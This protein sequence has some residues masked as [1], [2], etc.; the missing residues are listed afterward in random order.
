MKFNQEEANQLIYRRRSVFPADYRDESVPDFIVNQMLENATRAPTHKNTEPWRFTVFTGN[1]IHRLA[2]FQSEVY[3]QV[4]VKDGSFREQ[5]YLGL[6]SKPLQSACIIAVGMKR[7]DK[8]RVP[9]VEEIGAVFCA[10]ENMYLTAAAYGVG[11]YLSTGGVTYFEEAKSLFGLGPSDRLIGFLHV[12]I[13]KVW[14]QAGVR[15]PVAE[16]AQWVTE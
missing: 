1:G 5:R 13:P 7:D 4:T 2:A 3:K 10:V 12:G 14:P 11:C 9:E 15:R 6:Q 16:V 8:E